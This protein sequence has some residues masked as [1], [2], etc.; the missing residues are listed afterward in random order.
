MEE[1][2][3]GKQEEGRDHKAEADERKAEDE[4]KQEAKRKAEAERKA[5]DEPEA[6]LG[7]LTSGARG[8][9]WYRC[10]SLLPQL[11]MCCTP[12][13]RMAPTLLIMTHSVQHCAFFWLLATPMVVWPLF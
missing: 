13:G 8:L 5:E 4:R 1:G 7:R 9:G 3:G 6:D 2:G 12:E 11:F 10:C